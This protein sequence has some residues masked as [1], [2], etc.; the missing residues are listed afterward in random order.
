MT[1][2]LHTYTPIHILLLSSSKQMMQTHAFLVIRALGV[3]PGVP[4]GPPRAQPPPYQA[5]HICSPELLP[6]ELVGPNNPCSS[7]SPPPTLLWASHANIRNGTGVGQDLSKVLAGIGWRGSGES[8]EMAQSAPVRS[9][10]GERRLRDLTLGC[11]DAASGPVKS[12]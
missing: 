9:Q 7:A 8:L 11:K 1:H 10:P 12:H 2:S 4:G 5:S 6:R 3:S